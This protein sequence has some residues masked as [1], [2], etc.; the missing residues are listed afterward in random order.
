MRG[1]DALILMG[2]APVP[3][4]VKTRMCPPLSRREAAEF[5]AC[6]LADAA[7]EAATL[8]GVRRYLFYA[9][10]RGRAHFLV[11]PF[12]AFL[13][14]VQEGSDLGE[15]MAHAA[16]EAFADGAQRVVIIGADCPALSA[17]R[18]RSAFRELADGAGAVFGPAED[19]GF[20]LVGLNAPV[21]S[22]F[23]GVVWSAPTVLEEVLSR[24]RRAG[25][26]YALLPLESDV[27]TSDDLEELREWARAHRRP[28]CPQTRGWLKAHPRR[29][30]F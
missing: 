28:L 17:A 13:P 5:Y 23:G 29:A 21:P 27:D 1:D 10:P 7:G 22:L 25:I 14:R 30:R 15:R 3:G 19:G 11:G 16:G 20:Y 26:T 18:I 2:K 6:L 9:P 12:S 8:R 4:E 24:C